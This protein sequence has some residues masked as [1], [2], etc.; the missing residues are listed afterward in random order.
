[1]AL[2]DLRD[3][4]DQPT[5]TLPIGG[6]QYDVKPCSAKTW[7]RLQAY[8]AAVTAVKQAAEAKEKPK[9]ADVKA[10]TISEP[11]LFGMSLG[12]VYQQMI[13]SDDVTPP[14]LFQAGMTALLWQTGDGELAEVY[15]RSG[16]KV[17]APEA[18]PNEPPTVTPTPTG[19]ATTTRKRASASGTSTPK[20]SSSNAKAARSRGGKSSRTGI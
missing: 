12:D 15:W 20:K 4:L 6:K 5:L 1:M 8:R 18:E 19:E 14:E 16:G 3:V 10:S 7:M 9:P 2:D 13:N 17:P 11:V